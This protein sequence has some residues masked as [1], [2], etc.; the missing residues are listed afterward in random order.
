VEDEMG[1]YEA[2]EDVLA[3]EGPLG[4]M[5]N[6]VADGVVECLD[7]VANALDGLVDHL[8]GIEEDLADNDEDTEEEPDWDA[9][10]GL[11]LMKT[12]ADSIV[13]VMDR[14]SDTI[15]LAAL[16]MTVNAMERMGGTEGEKEQNG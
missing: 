3:D 12:A 8:S 1:L 9:E 14:A 2:L 13:S 5:A 6:R 11:R 7:G 15:N 16:K 10:P 4:E